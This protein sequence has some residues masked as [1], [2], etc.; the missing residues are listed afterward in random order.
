M[1]STSRPGCIQ[2]SESTYAMLEEDQRSL[3]EAT[4]GVEV[5]GK[6]LMATYIYQPT[7]EELQMLVLAIGDE[8][9]CPDFAGPTL[10]P[11]SPNPMD[12]SIIEEAADEEA[13]WALGTQ[14]TIRTSATD[15]LT[16]T[17]SEKSPM[18]RMMS[19]KVPPSSGAL[20][21][22]RR[23]SAKPMWEALEPGA[24][25]PSPVSGTLLHQGGDGSSAG[26][27]PGGSGDMPKLVSAPNAFLSHHASSLLLRSSPGV[28]QAPSQ[29]TAAGRSQLNLSRLNPS[30]STSATPAHSLSMPS[31]SL[32][33]HGS[34]GQDASMLPHFNSLYPSQTGGSSRQSSSRKSPSN[35]MTVPSSSPTKSYELSAENSSS[36]S[37]DNIILTLPPLPPKYVGHTAPSARPSFNDKPPSARQSSE[38]VKHMNQRRETSC[39][40][41]HPHPSSQLAALFQGGP[42]ARGKGKK[43]NSRTSAP[44]SEASSA[45]NSVS[46]L[47][48]ENIQQEGTARKSG[49]T[50][51]LGGFNRTSWETLMSQGQGSRTSRQSHSK[52]VSRDSSLLPPLHPRQG[53]MRKD[54]DSLTLDSAPSLA[55]ASS[56]KARR[57]SWTE[58]TSPRSSKTHDGLSKLKATFMLMSEMDPQ[59]KS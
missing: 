3:F 40:Y 12:L 16:P 58:L 22:E 48:M 57:S 38:Q 13:L 54:G 1:E 14:K 45:A 47:S 29:E 25:K 51:P 9:A 27:K 34:E 42:T 56:A 18:E 37:A 20:R 59:R 17:V 8:D 6:G 36:H 26:S 32:S 53:S 10:R 31:N 7:E 5:K 19:D 21:T 44:A 30:S 39:D 55:P 50:L 43:D 33:R 41:S 11:W 28:I 46:N 4:G 49:E 35:L 24:P 15:Y 52:A 2:V 23:K